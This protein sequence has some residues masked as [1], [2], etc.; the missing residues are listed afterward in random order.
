MGAGHPVRNTLGLGRA[1]LAIMAAVS[2]ACLQGWVRPLWLF[3]VFLYC[4]DF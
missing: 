2:E 1:D 4:F 3:N